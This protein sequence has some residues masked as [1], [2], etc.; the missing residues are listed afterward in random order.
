MSGTVRN[1]V[2]YALITHQGVFLEDFTIFV[3]DNTYV[4]IYCDGSCFDGDLLALETLAALNGAVAHPIEPPPGFDLVEVQEVPHPVGSVALP[5]RIVGDWSD[6]QSVD[7]GSDAGVNLASSVD[8]VTSVKKEPVFVSEPGTPA[9]AETFPENLLTSGDNGNQQVMPPEGDNYIAQGIGIYDNVNTT[10]KRPP[11]YLSEAFISNSI[12]DTKD[13]WTFGQ[14]F[15]KRNQPRKP[16]SL[17]RD[18][19]NCRLGMP[20]FAGTTIVGPLRPDTG[21]KDPPIPD[22]DKWLIYYHNRTG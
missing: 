15:A 4:T 5:D 7:S 22:H 6:D 17:S 2:R 11:R 14:A 13:I 1:L 21:G 16:M 12:F 8:S 19:G 18:L 3:K 9:G 20:V 10:S